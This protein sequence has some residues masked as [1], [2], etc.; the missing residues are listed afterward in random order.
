MRHVA[1]TFVT[2]GAVGLTS[3]SRTPGRCSNPVPRNRLVIASTFL[4]RSRAF[5]SATHVLPF[6][7]PSH[8][9]RNTVV[10]SANNQMSTDWNVVK[11]LEN[12]QICEEHRYVVINVG[13]TAEKGSLCDAFRVPGMYVQLRENAACKPGFF[14]ISCAPNVQGIFEFLIKETP[15]VAWISRL[16]PGGTV[17]MSPIMGNGFPIRK[18]LDLDQYPPLPTEQQPLD[19]L[20]F[21]TGSGIAPIR[22]AIESRLNGVEPS[23]RRSVKL[24]YGARYPQRMP[25]MDRF[26]LWESDGI[27]IIPVMSRP[28]DAHSGWTGR[29]GYI[30]DALKQDGISSPAQ[31][32]A[33]LCGVKGMTEDVKLILTT[34]GVADDRILFNY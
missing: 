11:V 33:L 8:D 16:K 34:A 17:E 24:Y 32:G 2:A 5:G 28:D 30:Q 9:V 10:A 3:L 18:R 27:E 6:S 13:T 19:I 21:A 15:H 12:S 14:S 22:S 20:L 1:T 29:T 31:T 4:R 7:L 23:R 25:Y 26:K